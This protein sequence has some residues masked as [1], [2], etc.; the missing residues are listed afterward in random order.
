MTLVVDT[1]NEHVNNILQKYDFIQCEESVWRYSV[2]SHI[3][4]ASE[5]ALVVRISEQIIIEANGERIFVTDSLDEL[6]RYLDSYFVLI[7]YRGAY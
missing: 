2:A 6:D 4:Y 3:R 5:Y 1:Q 7:R